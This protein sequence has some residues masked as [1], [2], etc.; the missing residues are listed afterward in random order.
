[1]LRGNSRAARCVKEVKVTCQ[2]FLDRFREVRDR[3][4]TD[5]GG[6]SGLPSTETTA[7]AADWKEEDIVKG[8]LSRS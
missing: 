8:S 5:I 4:L 1:M 2:G 7:S 3:I 6:A